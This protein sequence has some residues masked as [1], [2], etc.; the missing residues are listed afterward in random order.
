MTRTKSHL[1]RCRLSAVLVVTFITV[2]ISAAGLWQPGFR[3]P[4]PLVD[5]ASFGDYEVRI[6]C[7]QN[8]NFVERICSH[9][10]SPFSNVQYH[11]P[12]IREWNGFEILKQGRR[13]HSEYGGRGIQVT[14][15]AAKEVAGPDITGDGVPKLA[16][17]QEI[18]RQGG[19]SIQLFACGKEFR[20]IAGIESWGKYPELKD[21]D[22][23]GIPELI[24]SDN[25][26]YHW[27]ICMDGEPMPE[28]VLRWKSGHYLPAPELMAKPAPSRPNLEA[29]AA[30]VRDSS[31]WDTASC[32]APEA[33]WTNAVSLMYSGHE[34][35]AWE[36][37]DQAWKPGFPSD[38]STKESVLDN[39][40][41]ARLEQSVYWRGIRTLH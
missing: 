26:F 15:F 10:P 14:Q 34:Q 28:V 7:R 9:L 23:D 27:P 20:Q 2:L 25:A 36:F 40:I 33:L 16:V 39:G 11:L 29:L 8:A 5:S 17:S 4:G 32:S 1:M 22:S 31:G 18:G 24:V 35:L 41:R 37:I 3:P 21:L 19:G 12:G 6:Y 13:I 30:A 38:N